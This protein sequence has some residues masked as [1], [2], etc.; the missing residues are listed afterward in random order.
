V[1]LVGPTEEH[2][3]LLAGLMK[4]SAGEVVQ[5]FQVPPLYFN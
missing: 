1:L 2:E 3:A 5:L 4:S